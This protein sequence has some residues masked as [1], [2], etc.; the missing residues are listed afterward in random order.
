M[1]ILLSLKS[2]R[3]DSCKFISFHF[4]K[5]LRYTF[6]KNFEKLFKMIAIFFTSPKMHIL[7]RTVSFLSNLDQILKN[8]ITFC[9]TFF[10]CHNPTW[11]STYSEFHFSW[12]KSI[13]KPINLV[14]L[15]IS[16]HIL[17]NSASRSYMIRSSCENL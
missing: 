5:W 11:I 6:L 12:K 7:S 2:M 13:Y 14:N 3:L 17:Y 10:P 9:G 15:S 1:Q 16:V 4:S 8:D